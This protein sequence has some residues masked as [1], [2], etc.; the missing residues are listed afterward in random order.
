MLRIFKYWW[1][2]ITMRSSFILGSKFWKNVWSLTTESIRNDLFC[3]KLN[4]H[5]LDTMYLCEVSSIFTDTHYYSAQIHI[6]QHIMSRIYNMSILWH[7]N[8]TFIY[9]LSTCIF[10]VRYC[11]MHNSY[12][13][14]IGRKCS[15]NIKKN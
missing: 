5:P 12:H 7:Y 10:K 6:T 9:I 8:K 13:F 15:V 14:L 3:K 11:C 4:I 2:V 1:G